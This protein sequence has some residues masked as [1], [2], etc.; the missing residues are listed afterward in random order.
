MTN[1]SQWPSHD[2]HTSPR[3]TRAEHSEGGP[4]VALDKLVAV[5]VQRADGCGGRV[6]LGDLETLNHLPVA[7][8]QGKEHGRGGERVPQSS[9]ASGGASRRVPSPSPGSG[10][11]GTLSN[12]TVVAA[13]QRGP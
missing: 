1:D 11:I 3:P 5:L 6:Q 7:A 12:R 4:V 2:S 13:L 8:W 10:Y 9:M